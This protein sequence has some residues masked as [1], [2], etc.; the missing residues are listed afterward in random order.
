[1]VLQ[2][3]DTG[4]PTQ[5]YLWAEA[6]D[7]GGAEDVVWALG[8]HQNTIRDLVT[9]DP[10]SGDTTVA[11]HITYDSFGNITAETSAAAVDHLF[12]YT[13]RLFD[14]ATGLQNNLNRWY[15]PELGRWLTED[16]IGFEGGNGNLYRYCNDPVNGSDPSGLAWWN[17]WICDVGYAIGELGG[18]AWYHNNIQE[19]SQKVFD[20]YDQVGHGKWTDE[21]FTKK[22]Y[23][24]GNGP[25]QTMQTAAQVAME[26]NAAAGMWVRPSTP[27]RL[28]RPSK[29]APS[30]VSAKAPREA[31]GQLDEGFHYT[32]R[33]WGDA[34]KREG[35]RP[36]SYA[37][38]NGN[39]SGLGAKLELSLPPTRSA[40][41]IRIRIDL[42]GLRK[43]GY[44]IP[45]PTR[46]SNV[47]TGP[48]GRVY[49]MPGGGYEMQFP[50]EIPGEFLE[51]LP[52][53]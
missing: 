30:P 10:L 20:L 19:N 1:M 50:Y 49:T 26:W 23:G 7:D 40:P 4:A 31:V 11:N 35:L 48:D 5:R 38:P 16:P 44:E 53:R 34:I 43:A 3:D 45:R 51:V 2:L 15:D 29:Y 47:V 25:A 41:D 27:P 17:L 21:A 13:G 22:R 42:K 8:D 52:L 37:T 18:N 24:Y 9:Y 32:A 33:Q 14:E 46:V 36:G 6:V 28:P 12:G 39:L